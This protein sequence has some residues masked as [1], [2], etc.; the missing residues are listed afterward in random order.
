MN[1]SYQPS[2]CATCAFSL[3]FARDACVVQFLKC[4]SLRRQKFDHL[5]EG[6]ALME[7]WKINW[8]TQLSCSTS[9]CDYDL[10]AQQPT[11]VLI[12]YKNS[13]YFLQFSFG[14]DLGF[15]F[16]CELS[17]NCSGKW[18]SNFLKR[19]ELLSWETKK[20]ATITL[21]YH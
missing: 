9:V 6:C 8:T 19:G 10:W 11:S 7:R 5:A 21:P 3:S 20:V 2:S 16:F 1:K 14:E 18:F 12:W 15:A 13:H 4:S 17:C